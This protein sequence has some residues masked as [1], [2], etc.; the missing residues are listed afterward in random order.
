MANICRI[1][2]VIAFGLVIG[3]VASRA[4]PAAGG[5]IHAILAKRSK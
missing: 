4:A 3:A 5:A 1:S 2:V